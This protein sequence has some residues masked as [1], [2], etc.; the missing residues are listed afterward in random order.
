MAHIIASGKHTDVFIRLQ[1]DLNT[2]NT[3]RKR[4]KLILDRDIQ[5]NT[6]YEIIVYILNLYEALDMYTAKLRVSA[7]AL[8]TKTFEYNYLSDN[9]QKALEFIKDQLQLLFLLTKELES[10]AEDNTRVYKAS[11]GKL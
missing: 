5:W 7:D 10:N 6:S 8:N 3:T 4:Q 2:S 1:A 9:E 11:H